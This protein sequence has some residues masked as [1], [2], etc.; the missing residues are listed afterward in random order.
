[1][2]IQIRARVQNMAQDDI[3]SMISPDTIERI[4]AQD[5]HPEFRAYVIGHEGE[6]AGNE[7]GFGKRVMQYF[8]EAIVQIAEKLRLGTKLFL[9]HGATNSHDGR[10]PIGEVVGKAL[11]NIGGK[12]HSIAAVYID[13]DYRQQELDVAS[14]EGEIGFKVE[15]GGKARALSIEDI[16]G[17]ALASSKLAKPA[18]PGATL[19]GAVQN[20][21][22]KGGEAVDKEEVLK[23]IRELGLKITDIFTED[24]IRD[25]EPAK[26]AKQTEYEHAKRVEKQLGEERGK[27][28]KLT[29]TNET[30]TKQV[31]DLNAKVNIATVDMVL[32]AAIGERKLND[33]QKAFVEKK[34]A[35]F[36]SDKA[37]DEL[38]TDVN[39]FIDSQLDEYKEFAKLMG[40]KDDAT[41]GD[42]DD[43]GKDDDKDDNSRKKGGTGNGD[44]SGSVDE[45][46]LDPKNNDFIPA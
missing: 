7:V 29:E 12:L 5:K 31:S 17:I 39:R 41:G 23:A 36:K 43:K 20:F 10:T 42:D 44:G 14:F 40:I 27:V 33:K 37:G 13:P 46:L 34:K 28:L 19:L 4:K 45:S 38:K 24:E 26:K 35:E 18:F 25:S 30:L 22:R 3:M 32:K 9:G 15:G 1:M 6:A 16:T 8:R 11:K 2:K 21:T